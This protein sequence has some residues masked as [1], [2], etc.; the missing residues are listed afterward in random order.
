MADRPRYYMP[1]KNDKFKYWTSYRT[2]NGQE[3]GIAS[4][5]RG[6]QNSIED[7]CPFV[8][9]KEKIPVNRVVVK[10]QTH[11]GTEDLGP[12]SS[13][14]GTFADPFFGELNQQVP[15]KWKIQL[16]K[17]GNWEDT[18]SF[19]SASMKIGWLVNN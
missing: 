2:E 18:I 10:M 8:V 16:L 4:N 3:Y 12:F 9:Y 14:T 6:S 13:S 17:N 15:S 11:T 1:D 19:N 5:V 7:A